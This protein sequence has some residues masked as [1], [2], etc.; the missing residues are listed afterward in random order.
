MLSLTTP[1]TA[2][3]RVT[4]TSSRVAVPGV[5]WTIPVETMDAATS[6]TSATAATVD[7]C[8]LR[9]CPIFASVNRF[10]TGR[11]Y[12]RDSRGEIVEIHDH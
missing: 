4:T 7:R 1:L 12:D 8:L 2:P 9:P 6:A 10:S 3:F 5:A 11:R